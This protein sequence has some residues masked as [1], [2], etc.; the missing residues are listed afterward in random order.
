MKEWRERGLADRIVG[1]EIEACPARVR[2]PQRKAALMHKALKLTTSKEWVHLDHMAS[3]LGVWIWAALLARHWLSAP[4]HP[5][6][7]ARQAEPRWRRLWPSARREAIA[8]QRGIIGLYADLGA[9]LQPLVFTSD[10]EGAQDSDAGGY[11]IAAAAANSE[12]VEKL[13]DAGT[14]P[15]VAVAKPGQLQK[16]LERGPE[17]L[18]PHLP[19][20]SIE[21]G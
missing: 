19:V 16:V 1:C 5:F 18:Q 9:P 12:I 8:M 14:K 20:S 21:R 13:W 7:F 15:G 3:V 2:V 17:T 4:Q 10:A 6:Q 11:G